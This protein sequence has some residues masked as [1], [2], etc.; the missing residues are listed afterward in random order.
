ML[1]SVQVVRE[2]G[3]LMIERNKPKRVGSDNG[4]EPTRNAPDGADQVRVEWHYIAPGKP[5]QNGFFGELRWSLVR[6]CAL[7]DAVAFNGDN[8]PR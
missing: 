2:L 4:N 5:T 1:S 6:E 8:N 3:R 7:L